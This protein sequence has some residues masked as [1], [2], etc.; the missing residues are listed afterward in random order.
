[1]LEQSQAIRD[2]DVQAV[3]TLTGLLQAELQ[4]RSLIEGERTRLLER[5]G[6]RLGVGPGSVTIELLLEIMDPVSAGEAAVRSAELRGL[7][8]QIQREHHV[9]RVL[10]N[11][12]LAFLDHLL[13]L[14][15]EDDQLG[16]DSVG[17]HSRLSPP[18]L[19]PRHRVLD[20]EV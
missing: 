15:D 17:D 3:V 8:E 14:S 13:R 9:N 16:Y 19:S 6:V 7:L 5:A 20:V 10:M 12:E 18:R 2:R 4:R 11:Q 1:M